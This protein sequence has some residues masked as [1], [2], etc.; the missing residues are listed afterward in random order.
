[1][2]ELGIK[3]DVSNPAIL[4]DLL[5]AKARHHQVLNISIMQLANSAPRIK[6]QFLTPFKMTPKDDHEKARKKI[7]AIAEP[8]TNPN[9]NKKPKSARRSRKI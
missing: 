6:A 1:M 7:P 9:L 8:P 2:T 5:I 3:E 4:H